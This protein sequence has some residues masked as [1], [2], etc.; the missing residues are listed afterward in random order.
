MKTRSILLSTL[1]LSCVPFAAA[2]AVDDLSSPYV[3]RGETAASFETQYNFDDEDEWGGAFKASHGVTDFWEVEVG[4]EFG[5]VEDEDTETKAVAIENKFQLAQPGEFFVDPGLKIEYAKATNSDPDEISAALLLAKKVG[6]FDNIANLEIA[7]E[8]GEDSSDDF[9]YGLS[10][11]L[12][13]DYREDFQFG[14]EW[15]SDFGD[16]SD[17]FDEQGHLFGPVVYGEFAE[18]FGYEAGVLVGVSEG[19]PDAAIK[20]IVEYEF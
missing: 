18:T 11:A 5:D 19:A 3:T 7:R 15:H 14:L 20:A 2:H 8:V 10:Y 17:D 4:V 12:I 1:L 6:R 9:G 16:F 13:Y